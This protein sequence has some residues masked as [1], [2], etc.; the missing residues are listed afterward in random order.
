[1]DNAGL[2]L[3]NDRSNM[4]FSP[5]TST[6][7]SMSGH[8][9]YAPASFANTSQNQRLSPPYN[10][11]SL[12][13]INDMHHPGSLNQMASFEQGVQHSA[14]AWPTT[15]SHHMPMPTPHA[16]SQYGTP[17]PS[18]D[19]GMPG[20]LTGLLS[21]YPE[22]NGGAAT[23]ADMGHAQAQDPSPRTALPLTGDGILG[24]HQQHQENRGSVRGLLR[25]HVGAS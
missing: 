11:Q 8:G 16:P 3:P 18:W 5:R 20:A 14:Q 19:L 25:H 23:A 13:G 15:P 10:R 21:A 4:P 22:N 9:G 7:R 24:S 6:T 2:Y 17:R 12:R 1:M